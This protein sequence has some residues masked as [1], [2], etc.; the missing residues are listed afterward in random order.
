MLHVD[1]TASVVWLLCCL[2]AAAV[3]HPKNLSFPFT[4]LKN[5][6]MYCDSCCGTAARLSDKKD[7]TSTQVVYIFDD[8]VCVM[9]TTLIV[10]LILN[11]L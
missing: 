5:P 2:C 7:N 1:Y 9:Y 6:P 3:W 4:S 10:L 11:V 8:C